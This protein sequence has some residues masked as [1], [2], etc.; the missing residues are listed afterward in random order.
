MTS[1]LGW[2][3]PEDYDD[4]HSDAPVLAAV[5]TARQRGTV[6]LRL[7]RLPLV[8]LPMESEALSSWVSRAAQSQALTVPDMLA[9]LGWVCAGDFDLGLVEQFWDQDFSRDAFFRP[10]EHARQLIAVSAQLT[11]ERG[12]LLLRDGKRCRYRFC[13]ECLR[14]DA[15]P[16]FRQEWRLDAWR[17]CWEHQCLMEDECPACGSPVT[18][19]LNMDQAVRTGIGHLDECGKCGGFLHAVKPMYLTDAQRAGL[20]EW[21]ATLMRNGRALVA[22]IRL[23]RFAVASPDGRVESASFRVLRTLLP[24]KH[25]P[26]TVG[27]F[28]ARQ[29]RPDL[30]PHLYSG[31]ATTPSREA[32]LATKDGHEHN[33]AA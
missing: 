33:I 26:P 10:L 23:Q 32:P 4:A 1:L 28:R 21:G 3:L 15:T 19:P 16:Y 30:M 2:P 12:E 8:P 9:H 29:L 27:E 5:L 17:A 6:S 7:A 20:T 25:G 31:P 24:S 11:A 18:L 13:P 14:A 22:C